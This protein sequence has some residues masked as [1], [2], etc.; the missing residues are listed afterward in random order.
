MTYLPSKLNFAV[1]VSWVSFR[2]DNDSGL[3]IISLGVIT[4]SAILN[5]ASGKWLHIGY[6]EGNLLFTLRTFYIRNKVE[7]N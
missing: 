4:L 5:Q 2:M 7:V 6:L 1:S 3:G